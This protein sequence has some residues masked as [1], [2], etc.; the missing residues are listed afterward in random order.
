MRFSAAPSN[1]AQA[2]AVSFLER[3]SPAPRER[4]AIVQDRIL[5]CQYRPS[6]RSKKRIPYES[7]KAVSTLAPGATLLCPNAVLQETGTPDPPWLRK[8]QLP[9]SEATNVLATSTSR[10]S[11]VLDVVGQLC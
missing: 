10:N 9:F 2:N 7:A 4:G 8:H 5:S 3:G 1:H 11:S 6:A